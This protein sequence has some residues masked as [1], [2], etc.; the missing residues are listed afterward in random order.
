MFTWAY[1]DFSFRWCIL[2]QGHM[3]KCRRRSG[4][5]AAGGVPFPMGICGSVPSPRKC[6]NFHLKMVC[7]GALWSTVFEGNIPATNGP[8]TSLT[9]GKE[10]Q[11]SYFFA[12]NGAF[13]WNLS[14]D[15]FRKKTYRWRCVGGSLSKVCTNWCRI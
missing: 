6:L 7:S 3:V 9:L 13:W 8:Q 4:I 1:A 5:D 11:K 10:A 2:M 12:E 15:Q 14:S